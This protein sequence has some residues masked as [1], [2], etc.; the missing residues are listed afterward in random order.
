[1]IVKV[2]KTPDG[3]KIV[4]IC[5]SELIGKKI[6]EG[7]LQLDLSSSFYKGEEKNEE[8]IEELLKGC[9]V[10]NVVG[11]KSIDFIVKKGIVDEKNIIKIN[12]VP[13]AQAILG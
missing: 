4:A 6:E 3:R 2:H 9:C 12:N 8:E 1:M 10:V 7:R 5:D 13:H 11:E